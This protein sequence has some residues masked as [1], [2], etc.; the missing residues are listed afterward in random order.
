MAQEMYGAEAILVESQGFVGVS[1]NTN[2]VFI[3]SAPK[4][5]LNEAVTV[6]SLTAASTKLG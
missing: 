2:L 4:G 5:T 3:G 1:T 6:T